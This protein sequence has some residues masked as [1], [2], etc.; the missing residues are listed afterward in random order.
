[1]YLS[2]ICFIFVLQLD[3]TLFELN[4][5]PRFTIFL[6]GDLIASHLSSVVLVNYQQLIA[7]YVG[8]WIRERMV[9]EQRDKLLLCM[10]GLITPWDFLQALVALVQLLFLALWIIRAR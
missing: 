6:F 10:G 9:K 2:S 5:K 7:E 4:P 3:V 1:M 8:F